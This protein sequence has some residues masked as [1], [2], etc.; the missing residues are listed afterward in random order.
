M[1]KVILILLSLTILLC[2]CSFEAQ[3]DEKQTVQPFISSVKK[4]EYIKSV[5]ITYYELRE[6]IGNRGENEFKRNVNGAFKEL[7]L[8]GFNSVTVQVRAF[9]D[10]FYESDYFPLS[11]YC[12]GE[13]GG[14]MK[15]DVLKIL[16]ECAKENKLR[17]EAWVNPYRVSFDKDINKL[18]D[19]N[20]AK[21][22]YKTK[23][24]SN[25]YI[26]KSG[27]YFNPA[28]KDVTKL[29]VNGVSEIVKKYDVDAIHFDDYFYPDTNK[30]I[31]S[32]EYKKYGGKTS[33][34]TFRRNC[35]SLMI[36]E[37]NKAVKSADSTAEF[38]IS[39]AANIDNDYNNLYADVKRWAG[40]KSYCDGICPQVYF[41]FK[42]V[43]Q[44]F[45]F[46]VKK[47]AK[48]TENNLYIGLPLYKCGKK[49]KYA[50]LN[51]EEAINEFKNS[52]KIIARQINYLAKIDDIKGFYVFSYSSLFD[53]KCKKEVEN[54][55]KAIQSTHPNQGYTQ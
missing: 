17:I 5:W 45:M 47:W 53:E 8:M 55:I 39:P 16:C 10:A 26:C 42:N 32:A 9:A 36:K 21:K 13:Q 23:K 41:G 6:L 29:I 11:K 15:Y 4:D 7:Y 52:E 12:F 46:T 54:M 22:W 25:V 18:S 48:F 34:S 33:L 38:I 30:K 49:D 28:S 1:K 44:P 43:Y 2:G 20:V 3:N 27:I 24:K 51:D 37:V 40:D 50:A 19:N 14:E 35:V 31:D